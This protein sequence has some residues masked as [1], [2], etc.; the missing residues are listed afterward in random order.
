MQISLKST[1]R[2]HKNQRIRSKIMYANRGEF[3]DLIN[4][5]FR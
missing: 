4:T 2:K 5:S 3:S 1:L